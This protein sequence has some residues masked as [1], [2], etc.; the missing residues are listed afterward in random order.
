M[1][2]APMIYPEKV[3]LTRRSRIAFPTVEVNTAA[4]D[5]E[6]VMSMTDAN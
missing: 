3:T 5:L 2:T 6:T 1:L 4:T